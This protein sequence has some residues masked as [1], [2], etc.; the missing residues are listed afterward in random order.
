MHQALKSISQRFDAFKE[1]APILGQTIM[2]LDAQQ[3]CIARTY[4]ESTLS[5]D[6]VEAHH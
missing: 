2:S 1:G 3:F 4:S 5:M 6:K